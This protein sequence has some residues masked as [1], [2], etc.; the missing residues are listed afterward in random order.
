MF[1][2]LIEIQVFFSSDFISDK[3]DFLQLLVNPIGPCCLCHLILLREH[4]M[5]GTLAG[6]LHG[7]V[8]AFFSLEH[9]WDKTKKNCG[10]ILY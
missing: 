10:I 8:T 4:F 9:L 3:S 5:D 2:R 1:F 7:G 6:G